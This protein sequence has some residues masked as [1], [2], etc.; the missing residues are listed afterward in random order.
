MKACFLLSILLSL[1]TSLLTGCGGAKTAMVEHAPPT[2]QATPVSTPAATTLASAPKVPDVEAAVKRVFKDAAVV[3]PDYKNSFL[4][5]DFNGDQ[6]Q[7]L[8]VV[9]KPANLEAMNEQYPSWILRDPRIPY[10]PQK[11]LRVEK[12]EA[13]LAVIHGFGGNDWRDPQA[14]QTFLLKN[15]VG[16]GLRVQDAKE[17]LKDNAGRKLPRPQGD[18][19]GET[20]K[21]AEGYLY[22]GTASYAWY[23]P[24]TFTGETQTAGAFHQG[25]MR[26]P[27]Q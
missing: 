9:V 27:Q 16:S 2:Y 15:V 8:A 3:H 13:L 14:T 7:D 10:D 6:S 23:D 19:I 21:G 5:G 12:D 11:P 25:R 18:L 24:K 26:R 20:L 4:T 1:T 17:F 22:Y